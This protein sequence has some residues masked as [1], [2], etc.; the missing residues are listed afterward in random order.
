MDTNVLA[1]GFVGIA[2]VSVRLISLWQ[3]GG[4]ELVVSDHLLSELE[5]T[6]GDPYFAARVPVAKATSALQLL[7]ADARFTDLTVTVSGIATQPED[8]L[9]LATALSG[10]ASYLATRDKQLLKIGHYRGLLI[11]HPGD[12]L[13]LLSQASNI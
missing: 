7:R 11:L 1:P 6:F 5:R 13:D 9:V 8:D 2:S 10:G 12:V 4:Y 3:A